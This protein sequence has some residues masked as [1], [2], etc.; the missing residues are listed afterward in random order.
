MEGD[1]EVKSFLVTSGL[2]GCQSPEHQSVRRKGPIPAC[3][4]VGIA[5]YSVR[6]TPFDE[7]GV[8]GVDGNFYYIEPDPVDVPPNR[9]EFGIHFDA[10]IPGSSG[11]IVLQEPGEWEDFQDFMA[12]YKRQGF[13]GIA[14]IVE[15][16]VNERTNPDESPGTSYFTVATPHAGSALIAH[17]PIEFSGTASDKVA[18]IIAD[19]GPGGPFKVGDVVPD[20][21]IWSFTQ[22]FVTPGTGR[23]FCFR[24]FDS[25]GDLLQ[26]ISLQ[27]T[28]MAS[29]SRTQTIKFTG[30]M[31]T[32]GGPDDTGMTPQEGLAL[33]HRYE[34]LPD[35][36]LRPPSDDEGLGR[37]LNPSKYYLACPWNYSVAPKSILVKTTAKVTNPRNGKFAEAQPVDWGPH[38]RTGRVA[39]LSPGLADDLELETDDVCTVELSIPNN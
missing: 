9:G 5:N 34:D 24:A 4:K 33:V 20:G 37:L 23:P 27:F 11:C 32:F 38:P 12:K 15:Y 18:R 36:F 31:S 2:A 13:H 6:T 10:N 1:A 3:R 21:N 30:K 39:D 29:T 28:V 22:A 35:Y 25:N 8:V 17:E 19:V 26:K 7:R 14:L 16:N